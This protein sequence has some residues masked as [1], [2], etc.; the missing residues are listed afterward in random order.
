MGDAQDGNGQV[1]NNWFLGMHGALEVVSRRALE[2]Y[3]EGYEGCGQPPEED[4]FIRSCLEGLGV[5]PKDQFDT[6]EERD[7]ARDGV[8]QSPDWWDC[9]SGAAAYHPF[10]SPQNYSDCLERALQA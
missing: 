4:V 9:T 2:V 3:E 7:C 6:L 5:S 10:K 8:V 1:I